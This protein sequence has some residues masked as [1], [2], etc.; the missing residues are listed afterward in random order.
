MITKSIALKYF[1]AKA[2][3]PEIISPKTDLHWSSVFNTNFIWN[4][5]G[6]DKQLKFKIQIFNIPYNVIWKDSENNILIKENWT[7]GNGYAAWYQ[8]TSDDNSAQ[9]L[10]ESGDTDY[11]YFEYEGDGASTNYKPTT[12]SGFVDS[13][14]YLWRV[15]T[16]GYLTDDW[17]VW[18]NDG[19]LRVDNNVPE[20]LNL[21]AETV[22]YPQKYT[23]SEYD[24]V[25]SN[26][27]VEKRSTVSVISDLSVPNMYVTDESNEKIYGISDKKGLSIYYDYNENSIV[28]RCNESY[29]SNKRYYGILTFHNKKLFFNDYN[30]FLGPNN[31]DF[32]Y[33]HEI[34]DSMYIYQIDRYVDTTTWKG[35]SEKTVFTRDIAGGIWNARTNFNLPTG[36]IVQAVVENDVVKHDVVFKGIPSYGS[37]VYSIFQ[38][39]YDAQPVSLPA[40]KEPNY[41][42]ITEFPYSTFLIKSNKKFVF[43]VYPG[44]TGDAQLV[45]QYISD[46]FEIEID[47]VKSR[48]LLEMRF[49]PPFQDAF[50]V[51]ALQTKTKIKKILCIGQYSKWGDVLKVGE[52]PLDSDNYSFVLARGFSVNK[53]RDSKPDI[54][55]DLKTY[56]SIFEGNNTQISDCPYSVLN[57]GV[58]DN[59]IQARIG[60]TAPKDVPSIQTANNKSIFNGYLKTP[61]YS[62]YLF[63]NIVPSSNVDVAIKI[64]LKSESIKMI[65]NNLSSAQIRGGLSEIGD[66]GFVEF[67]MHPEAD[68]GFCMSN[69]YQQKIKV[70][71]IMIGPSLISPKDLSSFNTIYSDSEQGFRFLSNMKYDTV[72][73]S[74]V[75]VFP[76]K[77]EHFVDRNIVFVNESSFSDIN[78]SKNV[79]GPW[80]SNLNQNVNNDSLFDFSP[81]DGGDIYIDLSANLAVELFPNESGVQAVL[82][83]NGYRVILTDSN[84]AAND[85]VLRSFKEYVLKEMYGGLSHIPDNSTI[86]KKINEVEFQGGSGYI[87]YGKYR[88][89]SG[90]IETD[91]ND[92]EV[93]L[94]DESG[95]IISHPIFGTESFILH[96]WKHWYDS[97]DVLKRYNITLLPKKYFYTTASGQN[98]DS[99]LPSI[100]GVKT[101][102]FHKKNSNIVTTYRTYNHSSFY[103]NNRNKYLPFGLL[104]MRDNVG[105]LSNKEFPSSINSSS[106]LSMKN[107][108]GDIK[109]RNFRVHSVNTIYKNINSQY[110]KY[111]QIIFYPFEWGK[112]PFQ[113][114][115]ENGVDNLTLGDISGNAA[116]LEFYTS[117]S[118]DR[119]KYNGSFRISIP[120]LYDFVPYYHPQS[121]NMY[122]G[123]VKPAVPNIYDYDHD[124]I[125]T[126]WDSFQIKVSN[127]SVDDIIDDGEV[128]DFFLYPNDC[129]KFYGNAKPI[130][131]LNPYFYNMAKW[132]ALTS[133]N[134]YGQFV[135]NKHNMSNRFG[136]LRSEYE[137]GSLGYSM[138]ND[139]YSADGSFFNRF[140]DGIFNIANLS[141]QDNI[142][143]LKLKQFSN[144]LFT[145]SSDIIY[146]GTGIDEES[147]TDSVSLNYVG[148]Y[149]FGG[150]ENSVLTSNEV[151]SWI[152]S[153][154]DEDPF[155]VALLY[156]DKSFKGLYGE[157][158]ASESDWILKSGVSMAYSSQYLCF[159]TSDIF[160]YERVLRMI[161]E[162][163]D[164]AQSVII[165]GNNKIPISD[166]DSG[167]ISGDIFSIGN[168]FG[169][170][171]L[172]NNKIRLFVEINQSLSGISEYQCYIQT[173]NVNE[174]QE[175]SVIGNVEE[176]LK[177][178]MQVLSYTAIDG[179]R[180]PFSEVSK[181]LDNSEWNKFQNIKDSASG[182]I[183]SGYGVTRLYTDINTNVA[184]WNDK[185]YRILHIAVKNKSGLSSNI[186]S[187]PLKINRSNASTPIPDVSQADMSIENGN[188]LIFIDFEKTGVSTHYF[189]K[190]Y[191][192]N[193]E[194][195]VRTI[196]IEN[197]QKIENSVASIYPNSEHLYAG[198]SDNYGLS[199]N[200]FSPLSSYTP[201]DITLPIEINVKSFYRKFRTIYNPD[202]F[203]DPNHIRHYAPDTLA[204]IN[205]NLGSA[206]YSAGNYGGTPITILGLMEES[207][208]DPAIGIGKSNPIAKI[209]YENREEFIGKKI[210]LGCDL[211]KKFT[212]IHVFKTENIKPVKRKQTNY[213][214]TI[215][216]DGYN[217]NGTLTVVKQ[218]KVWIVVEDENALAA[219]ILSRNFEE[220]YAPGAPLIGFVESKNTDGTEVYKTLSASDFYNYKIQTGWRPDSSI[221]DNTGLHTYYGVENISK[222]YAKWDAPTLF[223]SFGL[224]GFANKT[225][226]FGYSYRISS[227]IRESLNSSLKINATTG[228]VPE[229]ITASGTT[230]IYGED[231][232]LRS[233]IFVSPTLLTPKV[234]AI[235]T[236]EGW[237]T[238]IYK[239]SSVEDGFSSFEDMKHSN[240]LGLEVFDRMVFGCE[241]NIECEIK[242]IEKSIHD[243]VNARFIYINHG[244]LKRVS[245]VAVGESFTNVSSIISL[246]AK[247]DATMSCPSINDGQGFTYLVFKDG[248]DSPVETGALYNVSDDGLCIVL[249]PKVTLL[250]EDWWQNEDNWGGLSSVPT[251]AVYTIK[252]IITPLQSFDSV[253]NDYYACGWWPSV[254]NV[255]MSS[256]YTPMGTNSSMTRSN[257]LNMIFAIESCGS[258]YINESGY[259]SFD[260]ISD[261]LS[262]SDVSFDIDYMRCSKGETVQKYIYNS[263]DKIYELKDV[264]GN[265][266]NNEKQFYLKS[267]WHVGRLRYIS[268]Y[269]AGSDGYRF[270]SLLYKKPN[271]DG[272][273]LFVGS[274]NPGKLFM[275]KGFRTIYG[276]I[277][278]KNKKKSYNDIVNFNEADML[279][280]VV[281]FGGINAR[282]SIAYKD[283]AVWV[284]D[285]SDSSKYLKPYISKK[286]VSRTYSSQIFEE[287]TGR[288]TSNVFDGGGDLRFWKSIS[289]NPKE[290]EDINAMD[291]QFFIRTAATE[292]ELLNKKWNNVG[293]D[294]SPEILAPFT[295]PNGNNLLK[296]SQQF[297]SILYANGKPIINRFIQ[298]GMI[299]KSRVYNKAP[300]VDDV[301]ISYSKEN[302]VNF[303]TTTFNLNSNIIKSILTYNGEKDIDSSGFSVSD[304]QFAI[305][306]KEEANGEVSTNFDD[307]K[308][309]PTNEVFSFDNLGIPKNDKFRVGIK[310]ISTTEKVVSVDE[311]AMM[312]E[313]ESQNNGGHLIQV[314]D[315]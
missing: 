89:D 24:F 220:Y 287:A 269:G 228:I 193:D 266:V 224:D 243:G 80:L 306:T 272:W 3:K 232:L 113:Y 137:F 236:Q 292:K 17:S 68:F 159:E 42:Y 91:F 139:G 145:K 94:H 192:L 172:S 160:K 288:Y 300:R 183:V 29:L 302:S 212:I 197:V 84:A 26:P 177:L 9:I 231:D 23:I 36:D 147:F 313:C 185:I 223:G 168:C 282:N 164:D 315:L 108:S 284:T 253:S 314:K 190:N 175:S 156:Y 61:L 27:I 86:V 121:I 283:S 128:K 246:Y 167:V 151:N 77:E 157:S 50:I 106:L 213:D 69:L 90:I 211:S 153:S 122:S 247:P 112:L 146:N 279:R 191:I 11:I 55:T 258:F 237:I 290:Q 93:T 30:G 150:K 127:S 233:T 289:W 14:I 312:F 130:G 12:M 81:S 138:Y 79:L 225:Q 180:I 307:Y 83:S 37:S 140:Y 76:I 8:E 208:I 262:D 235:S 267:G 221:Y 40:I 204:E 144:L 256:G 71:E 308:I 219:A 105:I 186:M 203:F 5:I 152:F 239:K 88:T 44:K 6:T 57:G 97:A 216:G 299:M 194:S 85:S 100:T 39:S 206:G 155:K 38:Y 142:Y 10:I 189:T 54:N 169:Y 184:G 74:D 1:S 143:K 111:Y 305:C 274:R 281:G 234:S 148:N 252:I 207:N 60:A 129:I 65:E 15:Q 244:V 161:P 294:T 158:D 174:N 210:I 49:P 141:K 28:L 304:I 249:D 187:L 261:A 131:Q 75:K 102:K 35:P 301:T 22:L 178:S 227:S 200:C 171:Y 163:N 123:A 255:Q 96:S 248:V 114:A 196:V 205:L 62:P 295:N 277:V 291:V 149:T 124:N 101:I 154:I 297:N 87:N 195:R 293:T 125:K 275:K 209:I 25:Q 92:I 19:L 298:F 250:G 107:L 18:A 70:D 82:S 202:W 116:Q 41:T 34:I 20:I 59:S 254:D 285:R 226:N 16:K 303:F 63:F 311:M 222:N 268:S 119:R 98:S 215:D 134:Y 66:L 115:V 64:K 179:T 296:F 132:E 217:S 133:S 188:S 73:I 201:W 32:I 218:Y 120:P 13:G 245:K 238:R 251:D 21:S 214:K 241:Y 110:G 45:E 278:N 229:R 56:Y 58:S 4:Y 166:G 72:G 103:S 2:K 240:I 181:I 136:V 176:N 117:Q 265:Y 126:E 264:G 173:I 109:V 273:N 199:F 242:K 170:T 286:A 135:L 33:P 263:S 310:F 276:K 162:S 99:I 43:S 51:Y 230:T 280:A 309:I 165:R 198:F 118:V 31:N 53:Y 104:Y 47:G 52:N 257:A 67:H 48:Y 260:I 78:D 7:S 95:D 182:E 46:G 259:Y 271:W 270:L